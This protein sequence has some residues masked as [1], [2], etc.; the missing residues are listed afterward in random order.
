MLRGSSY[1]TE[2]GVD[3]ES[4][5]FSVGKATKNSLGWNYTDVSNTVKNQNAK[6][7]DFPKLNNAQVK[8]GNYQM[9]VPSQ[10][11][12]NTAMKCYTPKNNQS[13]ANTL[14]TLQAQ[15]V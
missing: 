13:L 2:S 3:L 9:P 6:L 11:A 1:G 10:I 5:T 7:R 15:E 12:P 4:S 8:S 14:E